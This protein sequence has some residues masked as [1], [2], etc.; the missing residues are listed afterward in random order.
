MIPDSE[1]RLAKAV[2][3]LED[4]LVRDPPLTAPAVVVYACR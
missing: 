2:E 3:D 1:Q 4:L